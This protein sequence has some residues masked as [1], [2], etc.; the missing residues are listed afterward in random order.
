MLEVTLTI[1]HNK[2]A[3]LANL[4]GGWVDKELDASIHRLQS[5]A[6]QEAPRRSGRLANAHQVEKIDRG[7]RLVVRDV[8]Y[9]PFVYYGTRPH[10]I[11]PKQ[12]KVLHWGNVFA[13]YAH[14]PGTKPNPWLDRA[15]AREE[16]HFT[17]AI[18][19]LAQYIETY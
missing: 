16:G 12:K 13:A 18:S 1:K 7:W 5:Y 9:W 4:F 6:I 10:I 8:P 17:G 3:A 2:I 11:R 19:H 15:V 14:H